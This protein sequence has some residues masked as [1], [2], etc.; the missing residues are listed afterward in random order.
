MIPGKGD[1]VGKPTVLWRLIHGCGG[2]TASGR[3][4]TVDDCE[5]IRRDLSARRRLL[6]MLEVGVILL[7]EEFGFWVYSLNE[8]GR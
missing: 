8:N 7:T 6:I 3:K 4:M 2:Q 1:E 5:D